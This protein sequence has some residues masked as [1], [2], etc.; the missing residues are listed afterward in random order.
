MAEDTKK[1]MDKDV[2]AMFEDLEKRLNFFINMLNDRMNKIKDVLFN[3]LE[4]SNNMALSSVK[5]NLKS[6]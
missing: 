6:V 5:A 1:E 2:K 3:Y 4:A